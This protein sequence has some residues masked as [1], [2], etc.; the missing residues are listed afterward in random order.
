MSQRWLSF[1]LNNHGNLC[2]TQTLLGAVYD[3][4]F[5]TLLKQLNVCVC[6]SQEFAF[7]NAENI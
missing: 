6:V 2:W 5:S 3:Q 7:I 4:G 1:Y